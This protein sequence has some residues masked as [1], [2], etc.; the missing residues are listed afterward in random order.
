MT[1]D[2]IVTPIKIIPTHGGDVLHAFKESSVGF[3]R[4]GEAY[5]SEIDKGAIK[6]WKKHY[7]M[8]LNI[9]VPVGKIK[10]VAYDDRE[11]NNAQFHEVV[12]S[13]DNYCR[14]TI[15]PMVW[16]G[17]QGLSDSKSILLNI[18]NIEHDVNEVERA[19]LINIKY[20]W[21]N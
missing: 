7:K 12:L 5:F 19:D 9:V 20:N 4:F 3:E 14:L 15:P 6:A 18:A 17:F 1:K 16:L 13:R 8:T 11:P 2:I 21:S 10:F